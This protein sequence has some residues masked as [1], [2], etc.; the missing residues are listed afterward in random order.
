MYRI[1]QDIGENALAGAEES[2]SRQ[3]YHGGPRQG[4]SS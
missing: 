3:G 4:T 2:R 1:I